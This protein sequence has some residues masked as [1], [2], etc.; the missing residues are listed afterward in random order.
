MT[1]DPPRPHLVIVGASTRAAAW[2]AIRGGWSPWCADLF[3]D[4]DLQA[5]ASAERCPLPCFPRGLLD[6]VERAPVPPGAPLLYT[7]GLE[8]HPDLVDAL[9]VRRPLLGCTGRVL[10]RLRDP[11][12]LAGLPPGPYLRPADVARDA[13]TAG[14]RGGPWLVKPLDGTGGRGIG[15]WR[16]GTPLDPA[17]ILQRRVAGRPVSFVFQARPGCL[18]L[19]G[20]TWQLVGEA[21]FAARP[22]RYCGSIGPLPL[23][24]QQLSALEQLACGLAARCAPRGLLG[25]DA[26]I[27]RHGAIRPIEINPRYTASVEVIERATGRALLSAAACPADVGPPVGHDCCVGKAIAFARRRCV[28]PDLYRRFAHDQIADVPA[29]GTVVERGWPICTVRHV[30][31]DVDACRSGLRRL[32]SE[33]YTRVS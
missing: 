8:N 21:D 13:A 30:A 6:L 1:S 24:P 7:G 14:R 33:V 3:A 10:R 22:F 28:V 31:G 19:M 25:V 32:A 4:V 16:R 11:G 17:C 23:G 26:L 5:M 20:A 12:A 2:S 15:P 18:Q 27:D 9:A 29:A